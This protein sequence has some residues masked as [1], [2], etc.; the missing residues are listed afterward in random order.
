MLTNA[1]DAGIDPA[2]VGEGVTAGGFIVMSITLFAAPLLIVPAFLT[3]LLTTFAEV[4]I[5]VSVA[6][7]VL[8]F[9][10]KNLAVT[11]WTRSRRFGAALFSPGVI[12]HHDGETR[13]AYARNSFHFVVI[14]FYGL[15][16]LAAGL[17]RMFYAGP[18]SKLPS[19]GISLPVMQL[20]MLL[21]LILVVYV[22]RA[23]RRSK[24]TQAPSQITPP[25]VGGSS[26]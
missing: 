16:L 26:Q 8:W 2:S 12:E 3:W 7:T 23:V 21:L 18:G 19:P 15:W 5:V 11:S 1:I 14:W 24:A 13:R 22:F 25:Q 4:W 10:R 20:T 17:D 6:A 9:A